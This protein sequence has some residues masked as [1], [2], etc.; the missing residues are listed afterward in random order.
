MN[1][2]GAGSSISIFSTI[3]MGKTSLPDIHMVLVFGLLFIS[4]GNNLEDKIRL[5][6][7][8]DRYIKMSL[9]NSLV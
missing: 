6:S 9:H 1:S 8:F 4:L 2:Y 7:F 5:A 3:L